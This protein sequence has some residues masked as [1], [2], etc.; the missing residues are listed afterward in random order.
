MGCQIYRKFKDSAG[1]NPQQSLG[2]LCS[3]LIGGKN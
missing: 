3:V 2:H 1:K